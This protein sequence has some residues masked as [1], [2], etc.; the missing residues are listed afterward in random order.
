MASVSAFPLMSAQQQEIEKTWYHAMIQIASGAA[1]GTEIVLPS[2]LRGRLG[3]DGVAAIAQR[4]SN[5]QVEVKDDAATESIHISVLSPGSHNQSDETAMSSP[6][7]HASPESPKKGI[8]VSR[9]ANAFILYRKHHHSD[10]VA[11]NPGLHN[12]EISK[13]IG[14]MWR[15]ESEPIKKQWKDKAENVKR[16]HLR[17]H[18][19]YQYQPRKPHEKKRRMTKRKAMAL[20]AQQNTPSTSAPASASA[21]VDANMPAAFTT[22][23]P[24]P[25][26]VSPFSSVTSPAQIVDLANFN[27]PSL[28]YSANGDLAS[29]TFDS[30]QPNQLDLFT[31]LLDEHNTEMMFGPTT[32]RAP[33]ACTALP[34]AINSAMADGNAGASLSNPTFTNN[35]LAMAQS[36]LTS[37]ES[38][39]EDM[40]ARELETM[41]EDGG[42][43]TAVENGF[44]YND[45]ES[46]RFT[47]FLEQMPEHM[48]GMEFVN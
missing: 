46:Q 3:D 47:E 16:Q 26:T 19:D 45:L 20:A 27:D 28:S 42:L 23:S 38:S 14:K 8:K 24:T 41:E 44:Q 32:V 6:D 4:C 7:S 40:L 11:R 12:N 33:A 9:P 34:T 17:D 21:S 1:G 22:Y 39:L 25:S 48:W 35:D 5:A 13:I 2:D 30:F 36:D 37:F 15:D 18:P 10:I 29:F 43:A 31:N